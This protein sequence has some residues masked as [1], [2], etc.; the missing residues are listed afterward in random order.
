MDKV[1]LGIEEVLRNLSISRSTLYKEIRAR[2][3]RACKIGARTV[4]LATDLEAYLELLRSEGK[5]SD[6]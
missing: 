2:R 3:I 5:G 6:A 1:A 4:V